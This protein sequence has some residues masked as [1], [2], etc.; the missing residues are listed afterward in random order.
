MGSSPVIGHLAPLLPIGAELVRRGHRVQVLT[1]SRFAAQVAA[2]GLEHVL[3]PPECDYDATDIDAAFPERKHKK[4]LGRLRFDIDNIFGNPLPH[5]YRA[6]QAL[7]APGTVDAVLVESAFTGAVPLA[8]QPKTERPPLLTVGVLPMFHTSRDTAPGGLGMAPMAGPLG[9]LRNRL[10]NLLVQKV[11]FG[12]NQR[13]FAARLRESG[14]GELPVFFM[15]GPLLT[16]AILQ[17]T[18]PEF[19]FPRTDLPPG[20]VSYVGPVLPTAPKNFELPA[21]WPELDA[22]TPVVHVTQG[23]IDNFDLER[24]LMPTLRALADAEVL[25]VATTGGK[26]VPADIPANARVVQ[27]VPYAELLPK[28]DVMIT[29]GGYGGTQFALAHGVPLIVAGDSEDKPD[30]AAR[31][32]WSGAGI[33]LRTGKPAPKAIRAAVDRVLATPAYRERAGALQRSMAGLNA[34]VTVADRLEEAAGL[35]RAGRPAR[36]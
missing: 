34:V 31:V 30:V 19:E 27:F 9:R 7:L 8:K 12:P 23:T 17:L 35:N 28:V 5:Q 13:R 16:D 2:A 25:V 32:A 11:L 29:N 15:D 21:W 10:L 6:L 14:A 36:A 18:S 26:P 3:L 4:G 33:N 22:G 20:L 1:G 24:L